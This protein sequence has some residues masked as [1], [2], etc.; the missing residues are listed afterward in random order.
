MT[1]ILVANRYHT[2]QRSILAQYV[3]RMATYNIC[4]DLVER[5]SL[6]A[7]PKQLVADCFGWDN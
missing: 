3:A 6:G 4:D 5:V 1:H 2:Q 7:C